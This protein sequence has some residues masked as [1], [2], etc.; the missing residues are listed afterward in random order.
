MV[1][2]LWL[3]FETHIGGF[4]ANRW[5]F[6]KNGQGNPGEAL[7]VLSKATKDTSGSKGRRGL[8]DLAAVLE[9]VLQLL[10]VSSI[11]LRPQEKIEK[12]V[13]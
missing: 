12:Y 9:E 13:Q 1:M 4:F 7:Y 3:P 6:W 11:C 2:F 10:G 8:Y 5:A